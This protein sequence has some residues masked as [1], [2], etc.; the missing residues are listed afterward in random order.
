LYYFPDKDNAKQAPKVVDSNNSVQAPPQLAN[1]KPP[2]P[3]P[4]TSTGPVRTEQQQIQLIQ[5]LSQKY[6]EVIA[7]A[8]CYYS[9][10]IEIDNDVSGVEPVVEQK[11]AMTSPQNQVL[12]NEP[13]KQAN[14]PAAN[15][16]VP[17][18]AEDEE[19]VF[20]LMYCAQELE[21]DGPDEYLPGYSAESTKAV[22]KA[23]SENKDDKALKAAELERQQ[24]QADLEKQQRRVEIEK[25]QEKERA[26]EQ[27]RQ[28]KQA[29]L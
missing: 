1:S 4:V 21:V 11:Q 26:L 20:P 17:Q 18:L 25:Q 14:G 23:V 19:E 5:Q 12:Q 28:Q 29:E 8:F 15:Q 7:Q 6:E 9:Q 22:T 13:I 10:D 24:K 3:G 27:Q 16:E 2:G